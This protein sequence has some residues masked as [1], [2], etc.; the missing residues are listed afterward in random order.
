M[1]SAYVF[2]IIVMLH[3]V[4]GVVYLMY[5]MSKKSD[6]DEKENED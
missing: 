2:F 4:A 5:K 6:S 1:T 3:L